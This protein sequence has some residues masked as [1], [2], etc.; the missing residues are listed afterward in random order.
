MTLPKILGVFLIINS[1]LF[2]AIWVLGANQHKGFAITVATLAFCGGLFLVVSSQGSELTL[3]GIGSVKA[4]AESARADATEIG[5]IRERVENQSATIDLVA[6]K[7]LQAEK[8]A[9]RASTIIEFSTAVQAA[10]TDDRASY[11]VLCQHIA[12]N[13]EFAPIAAAIVA[14]INGNAAWH[15][16]QPPDRWVMVPNEYGVAT[17]TTLA[18]RF[19]A[20]L[21]LP[22]LYRPHGA[23]MVLRDDTPSYGTLDE[24]LVVAGKI[25]KEDPSLDATR[26]AG[27]FIS[28][29]LTPYSAWKPFSE[30]EN[31]LELLKQRGLK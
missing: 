30:A 4:L 7:A 12:N 25:L 10:Q 3:T 1:L 13:T 28:D 22:R 18:D 20:Y 9:A 21:K 27:D 11:K 31:L 26:I 15:L 29:R 19:A 23:W 2:C 8:L 6:S 17:A 16:C 5:Q 24:R 14:A